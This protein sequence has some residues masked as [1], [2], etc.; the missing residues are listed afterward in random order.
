MLSFYVQLDLPLG[1]SLAII[2]KLGKGFADHNCIVCDCKFALDLL[3][4]VFAGLA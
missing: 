1:V 3:A 4:L 2:V